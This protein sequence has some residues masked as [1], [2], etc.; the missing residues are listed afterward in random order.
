MHLGVLLVMSSFV[1]FN[2]VIFLQYMCWIIPFIP[3]ALRDWY[4]DRSRLEAGA[5]STPTSCQ[6][7]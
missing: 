4:P 1:C 2:S 6:S 5:A 7:S 3:L